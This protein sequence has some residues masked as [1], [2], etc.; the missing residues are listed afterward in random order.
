MQLDKDHSA[1]PRLSRFNHKL[2]K[3]WLRSVGNSVISIFHDKKT[4]TMYV[5]C[6][7]GPHPSVLGGRGRL[8]LAQCPG[9]LPAVVRDQV[10]VGTEPGAPLVRPV[11][12][13]LSYFPAQFFCVWLISRC[14]ISSRSTHVLAEARFFFFIRLSNS[15]CMKM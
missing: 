6:S 3:T 8:F 13:L 10:V 1:L 4:P 7:L 5:L 11:L 14:G 15:P 9:S 2:L 12:P